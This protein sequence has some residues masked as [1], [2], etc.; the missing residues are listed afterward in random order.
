MKRS[1]YSDIKNI[2][3]DSVDQ[4]NF[5]ELDSTTYNYQ[6]LEESL[7]KPLKM[8]L[9]FGRP[10]TGKSMIL[11][12]LY[13]DLKNSREIHYFDAPILSEKEFLKRIYEGISSRK[14][15]QNMRV[16]FDGL[17]KFCQSLRG[18]REIMF[19]LDE[20]QLYSEALM[21]KIRLLSDTRVVKFVITLHKT[22][23]EELIAKEHFKTRI[24]EVIELK[25]ATPEE[26]NIYIKKKLLQK[27]FVEVS[28]MITKKDIKFIHTCTKGNFRETNKFLYTIFNIYEYYDMYKPEKIGGVK[29]SK[30][31]LE[32]A[33]I[34]IG[35]IDD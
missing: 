11:N 15:P 32:M 35:Y 9:L 18:K 10:G 33:A 5:V 29:L 14:I 21:E 4:E 28:N 3:I 16:N 17:L 20:C 1:K 2:F 19:L 23:N 26:L 31:I 6:V 13:H 8:I 27:S 22:E 12:K 24:W 34:K 30:K 7:D 25:N